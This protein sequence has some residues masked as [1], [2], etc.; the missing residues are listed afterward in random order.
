MKEILRAIEQLEKFSQPQIIELVEKLKQFNNPKFN[1]LEEIHRKTSEIMRKIGDE[2]GEEEQLCWLFGDIGDLG[3]G[4]EQ[5][6]VIEE[7]QKDE[8]YQALEERGEKCDYIEKYLDGNYFYEELG[9]QESQDDV[10]ITILNTLDDYDPEEDE[11][12]YFE[13][14]EQEHEDEF[15]QERGY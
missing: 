13:I 15:R 1:F 4:K 14:E 6:E 7:L 3:L 12:S 9:E 11:K 8:K 5:R 10:I 2:N